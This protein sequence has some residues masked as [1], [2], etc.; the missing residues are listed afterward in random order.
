MLILK[1]RVKVKFKDGEEAFFKRYEA[2]D[3]KI[4]KDA[5]INESYNQDINKE[6]LA[7]LEKLEK[8]AQNDAKNEDDDI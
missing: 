5:Q 6:E 4:I 3:V 7:E 1:E 8:L 2:A